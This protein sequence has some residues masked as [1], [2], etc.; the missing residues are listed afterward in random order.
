MCHTQ[1]GISGGPISMNNA[2][3]KSQVTVRRPVAVEII[4]C[5]AFVGSDR[6]AAALRPPRVSTAL[7]TRSWPTSRAHKPSHSRGHCW[8]PPSAVPCRYGISGLSSVAISE[9]YSSLGRRSAP[10]PCTPRASAAFRVFRS[11]WPPHA[12]TVCASLWAVYRTRIECS[13]VWV[14]LSARFAIAPVT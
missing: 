11:L 13:Q 3:M 6:A 1:K 4:G 8:P 14:K 9:Q 12:G 2:Q 5:D 10:L 7:S